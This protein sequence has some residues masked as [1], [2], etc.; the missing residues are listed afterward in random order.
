MKP[1]DL[2]HMLEIN[3]KPSVVYE[4]ITTQ[5]GQASWWTPDCHVE[6]KV[7][8]AAQFWF[9][10]HTFSFKMKI[11]SLV[12]NKKVVWQCLGNDKE[13]KGTNITF[14]L[15]P[16]KGGTIVHLYHEGWKKRSDYQAS[17]NFTWSQILGRLKTYAETGKA[18]PYFTISGI[19]H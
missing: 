10:N 3:A 1:N 18:R 12:K 4:A 6:P 13:W 5:K 7:G 9:S 15:S 2:R 11:T 17:C 19:D 8:T 16:T 14:K